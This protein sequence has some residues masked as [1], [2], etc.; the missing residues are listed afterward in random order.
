MPKPKVELSL[1]NRSEAAKYLGVD[2]GYINLLIEQGEI[3]EIQLPYQ[4]TFKGR[5]IPKSNLDEFIERNLSSNISTSTL[6]QKYLLKNG[7][8]NEN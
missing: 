8:K 7:R 3:Q 4:T 5:R 1:F 6:L 2:R